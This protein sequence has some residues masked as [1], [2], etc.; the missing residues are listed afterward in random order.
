MTNLLRE[1]HSPHRGGVKQKQGPEDQVPYDEADV[2]SNTCDLL[3]VV[4]TRLLH[5][6]LLPD[7][8]DP[9]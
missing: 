1:D 4:N 3:S 2:S 8:L 6:N 7:L 9:E 5:R